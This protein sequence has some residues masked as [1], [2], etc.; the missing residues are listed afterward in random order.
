MKKYSVIL[1][2][3]L[4]LLT[5]DLS[6][7]TN[8]DSIYYWVN[9][10]FIE[11]VDSGLGVCNCQKLNKYLILDYN[12]STTTLTIIPS[13]YHSWETISTKVIQN[14]TNIYPVIPSY[15]IDSGYFFVE[16]VNT[17]LLCRSTEKIEFMK[18]IIRPF[19]KNVESDMSR[20]IGILSAYHF[21][22]FPTYNC[23]KANQ[24][25]ISQDSIRSLIK[26]GKMHISC[27]D[28]Y[29]YDI[30]GIAG[31]ETQYFVDYKKGLF[32]IYPISRRDRFQKVDITTIKEC[33]TFIIK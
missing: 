31:S 14:S 13:I 17:S 8:L 1:I 5:K 7:Q 9:K 27:S 32:T 23:D 11:C 15:G 22:K 19:E 4:C 33:Q 6:S 28:D 20:Q 12:G 2:A 21:A 26:N 29:N 10:R 18:V 16:N 3:I 30:M 24:P 25:I